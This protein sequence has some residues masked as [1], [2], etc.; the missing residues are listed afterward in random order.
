M[1]RSYELSLP[2]ILRVMRLSE[3]ETGEKG[4]IVK[5]LGHGGFRKRIVEMGFIKGK[6]VEVLLNAPLRDPIKY[7]VLGYEISLR[8]QEA[9]MIE[10]VSEEEAKK[11]A[12]R[13][14]DAKIPVRLVNVKKEHRLEFFTGLFPMG[15][16]CILV[17]TGEEKVQVQLN[18][19]V[20]RTAEE[21]LPEDEPRIENP[22]LHLTAL[23]FVQ[24][25]RRNPEE[26]TEEMDALNEE[27][28]AHFYEGKYLVAVQENNQIPALRR[29]SGKVY[30]PI[31]TDLMEFVKFDKEQKY[32]AL[33]MDAE[34]VAKQLPDGMEGVAIN[35]FGVNVLLDISKSTASEEE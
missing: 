2:K 33:I 29:T 31:F 4:V 1:L 20:I 24:E 11:Q 30:Q 28:M 19:L 21:D 5:V 12:D 14:L 18:D 23:Y 8:R 27:M 35:P 9:E 32:R 10:V 15:V 26:M 6:T 7:K 16:N 3:L 25:L 13:M 22:E 17:C 34:T